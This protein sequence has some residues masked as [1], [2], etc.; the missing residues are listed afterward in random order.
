MAFSSILLL[1][2]FCLSIVGHEELL[3]QKKKRKSVAISF[4]HQAIDGKTDSD[5]VITEVESTRVLF[6][7]IH[8]QFTLRD[9]GQN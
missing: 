8:T 2:Y 5:S 7:M 9:K 3:Q 1:S 6:R 4:L